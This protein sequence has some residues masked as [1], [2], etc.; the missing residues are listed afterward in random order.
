MAGV[1]K[2]QISLCFPALT[3]QC[4]LGNAS[5]G[6]LDHGSHKISTSI[7]HLFDYLLNLPD[8]LSTPKVIILTHYCTCAR[9]FVYWE[10]QR[11]R[12]GPGSGGKESGGALRRRPLLHLDPLK[13]GPPPNC[14]PLPHQPLAHFESNSD[15]HWQ[16]P[17][18]QPIQSAGAKSL[19][20]GSC[21][22][23][24][25]GG[26]P[27]YSGFSPRSSNSSWRP[28]GLGTSDLNAYDMYKFTGRLREVADSKN[29]LRMTAHN[30]SLQTLGKGQTLTGAVTAGQVYAICQ[31]P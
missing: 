31:R 23:P 6:S 16:T 12:R 9:R 30:L 29:N 3:V 14:C 19:N 1:W 27:Y 22:E 11:R 17:N 25:F 20:P 24:I 28:E 13:L 7:G 26:A 10:R 15:N 2:A 5:K 4:F 18:H 8:R 21:Q